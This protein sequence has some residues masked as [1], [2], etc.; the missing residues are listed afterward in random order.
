MKIKVCAN[1]DQIDKQNIEVFREHSTGRC[2]E[3]LYKCVICGKEACTGNSMSC[4]GHRLIHTGCANKAFGYG[5]ILE[6]FKWVE[7]QSA[8][9]IIK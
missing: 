9:E 6:A 5:N 7:D 8:D 2:E 1:Y 3:N 4:R